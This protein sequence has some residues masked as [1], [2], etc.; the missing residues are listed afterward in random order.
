[1]LKAQ[2]PV[3]RLLAAGFVDY[4]GAG[5]FLAFSAVYFTQLVGLASAQV[6]LGLGIAGILALAAAPFL[7]RLADRA[8]P[9]RV[10]I[11]LHLLRAA[12]T[13]AYALVGGWWSFLAAVIVVTVADQAIASL[14][15]ALVADLAGAGR[16]ERVMALYRTAANLAISIG[17]PLGGLL[18]ASGGQAAY[19]L[20]LLANAAAYV[21]VALLLATLTARP[22]PGP[23]PAG[24]AVPARR[25]PLRDRRL[26]ALAG[27]DT[28]LQLWLPLLNLG[29]PLWLIAHDPH[30]RAWLGPLYTV[31]TVLCVLLQV[32]AARLVRD[33]AAAR[34]W[35]AAG[36]LLLAVSCLAF[37][38]GWFLPAVVLLS[39]G[40]LVAVAAAWTL[41][42]ALAPGERRAEYLS[43]F[44][45]GR[46]FS[47]YVLGPV[48]VTGLLQVAG[49]PAWGLLTVLFVLAGA[50]TLA[51]RLP[52]PGQ[53]D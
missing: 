41:S 19:Q 2:Y 53:P 12:G 8:G 7:G 23:H 33:P 43:A 40:E 16:R 25:G 50:A 45:M 17:G 10:L 21:A 37:W 27:V 26:L 36:A 42:Y 6:G 47:R 1:M 32:P 38:A 28:V 22:R 13:A 44:G 31:N 48:L 35:Q 4:L 11:L 20:V 3:R 29:F 30:L 46:S 9:R 15:Q 5:L 34:R 39:F 49:G 24:P 51:L 18:T 52:E 14:T